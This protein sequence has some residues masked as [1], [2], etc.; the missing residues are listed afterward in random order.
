MRGGIMAS[1]AWSGDSGQ[2][3]RFREIFI[4]VQRMRADE[5]TS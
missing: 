2:K 5:D 4:S 1:Q 3:N